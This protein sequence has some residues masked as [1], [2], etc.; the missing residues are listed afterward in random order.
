MKAGKFPP[1]QLSEACVSWRKSDIGKWMC[2][3]PRAWSVRK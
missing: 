3:S 1:N 2:E